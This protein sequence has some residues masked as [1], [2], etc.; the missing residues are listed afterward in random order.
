M[1]RSLHTVIFWGAGATASLG[2]QTT[3]Q[4]TKTLR[5]LASRQKEQTSLA[6]RIEAALVGKTEEPWTSALHDLLT[7]LGDGDETEEAASIFTI[8]QNQMRAMLRN[9]RHGADDDEIRNRIVTLRT[10]Y[11][12]PALKAVIDVCPGVQGEGDGFQLSDLFNVLDMHGQSGHGFRVK[13]GEFLTP[14]R[15]LG[16]R[17]ALKML[18][19]TTFY[20][21]WQLRSCGKEKRSGTPLRLR[22]RDGTTHAATVGWNWLEAIPP[23]DEREFYMGDVSFACFNWDPIA[24]WC[25]FVANRNLNQ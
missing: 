6:Q 12:W 17:N 2:M 13:E 4:Q 11:D 21:D 3:R 10:L 1:T 23:F 25:Q 8:T 9:W 18:L 16:A 15:V 20:I 22:R 19:Q 14:Q 7:I 24:L 5:D